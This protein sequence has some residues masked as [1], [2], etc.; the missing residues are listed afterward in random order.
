MFKW[1]GEKCTTAFKVDTGAKAGMPTA[2]ATFP[3]STTAS[4]GKGEATPGS[5]TWSTCDASSFNLRVGP[6]Y[7]RNKKKEPSCP[8]LSEIVGVE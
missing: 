5:N 1:V 4:N 2:G 7:N 8:S 6:D 3:A